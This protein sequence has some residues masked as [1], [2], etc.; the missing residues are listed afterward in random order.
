MFESDVGFSVSF[1][2]QC[3]GIGS[4]TTGAPPAAAGGATPARA[5]GGGGG[6]KTPAGTTSAEITIGCGVDSVRIV[7]QLVDVAPVAMSSAAIS[8]TSSL[9]RD[10]RPVRGVLQIAGAFV[11]RVL[12]VRAQRSRE[13]RVAIRGRERHGCDALLAP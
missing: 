3:C 5:G 9:R 12:R 7:S 2:R 11:L 8:M 1:T 10:A 6:V 13:S 4:R